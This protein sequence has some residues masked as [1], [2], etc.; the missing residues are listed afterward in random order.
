MLVA[1]PR[2]SDDPVA[3]DSAIAMAI[4]DPFGWITKNSGC[5]TPIIAFSLGSREVFLG[6]ATQSV[7]ALDLSAPKTWSG[8][9]RN[10]IG[11]FE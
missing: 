6:W 7:K 11:G 2:I 3:K 1:N 10:L 8:V 4:G 5:I 9:A